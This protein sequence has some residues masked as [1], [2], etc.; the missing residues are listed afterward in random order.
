MQIFRPYIDWR[1]SAAAL[2]D[3]RL[4]KQRVECKQVLKAILRRL[5]LINDGKR[6]WLNHPIVLMYYNDG[7]AYI[8]DLVSFFQACVDEWKRREFTS[9]ISLDDIKELLE[10]VESLDGTP[11]THVHE[12]EYRRILLIKNPEHYLK[13]FTKEELWEVVET[14]PVPINGI[15]LW[16]W[17]DLEKYRKFIE[18]IRKTI[19]CL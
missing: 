13:V 1:L 3:K 6:G 11:I 9:T 19:S 18:Q 12:V 5:N 2:D 14:E 16:I 7:R 4:G 8:Q 15:N 17:N 10:K